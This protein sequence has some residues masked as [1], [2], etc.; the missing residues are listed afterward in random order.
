MTIVIPRN[1][2]YIP[3]LIIKLQFVWWFVVGFTTAHLIAWHITVVI[4]CGCVSSLILV[5]R[6]ALNA[7]LAK[8]IERAIVASLEEPIDQDFGCDSQGLMFCKECRHVPQDHVLEH[9]QGRFCLNSHGPNP[10][11]CSGYKG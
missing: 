1:V 8:S 4:A 5:M 2:R 7:I 11:R 10:C 6:W 3:S 9:R